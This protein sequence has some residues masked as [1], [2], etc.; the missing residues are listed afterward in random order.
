MTLSRCAWKFIDGCCCLIFL[1]LLQPVLITASNVSIQR[2]HQ[3]PK[4]LNED[5]QDFVDIIINKHLYRTTSLGE[6]ALS[7]NLYGFDFVA[8]PPEG[9]SGFV[10]VRI[11]SCPVKDGKPVT[12]LT[13]E[14][15]EKQLNRL[16]PKG[17]RYDGKIPSTAESAVP[18]E[19][20][21]LRVEEVQSWKC[22]YRISISGKQLWVFACESN[23]N[24]YET[25]LKTF[26]TVAATFS[27]IEEKE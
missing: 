23:P 17:P 5:P 25:V 10:G 7:S 11:E 1:I 15:L 3:E 20:E 16:M 6:W 12:V 26:Y 4:S 21:V 24:Q 8:I 18:I 9:I 14:I 2:I 13:S 19:F 22:R 27:Y